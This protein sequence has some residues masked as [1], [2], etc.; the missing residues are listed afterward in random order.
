[1]DNLTQNINQIID[2]AKKYNCRV[3]KDVSLDRFTSFKIG[4]KCS[5]VISLNS[6]CCCGNLFGLCKKLQVPYLIIGNGSDLLISDDGFSGIVFLI[7]RE[8]S[9]INLIDENTIEC[10]A[11]C[12]IATVSYYAYKHGLSG[13]EFA[14]GIP[15]T[16]G[17]AVVMNA[18]AY[19]GEIKDVI[20]ST[21]Q[22]DIYGNISELKK[23]E[24]N[25]SYRHS[26]FSSGEYLITKVKFK[27]Y[28][29]DKTEI[30]AIMDDFLKRRKSKQP[31]EYPSAGS[32]FKRPEGTYAALLIEQCGL[33]GFSVGDAQVSEKH[34]GFVINKG[35]ATYSDVVSLI[36]HIKTVVHEKTGYNLECE[37]KIIDLNFGQ[38]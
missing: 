31:L 18:G 10:D 4:G 17:G 22:S 11:G 5:A 27:L 35:K 14:W 21:N 6:E 1:M 38:G 16:V 8:F 23:D 15:G 3:L 20:V 36:E 37:V 33:K 19:G 7:S 26:V 12:A 24:L 32:T 25:L 34:S 2:S 30:K 29:K 13:L 9:S 28:K